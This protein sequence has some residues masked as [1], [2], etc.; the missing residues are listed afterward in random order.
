MELLLHEAKLGK[1]PRRAG[2]RWEGWNNVIKHQAGEA[3]AMRVLC[4]ALQVPPDQAQRQE[5]LAFVHDARKHLEARRYS[6]FTAQERSALRRKMEEILQE[7]DPDERLLTA[8]NETFF[9][10]V[11]ERTEGATW[12]EKID[13]TPRDELLQYYIDSLFVNGAIVP[14]LERIAETEQRRQD[15]NEDVERTRRLGMKYWDAERR[16]A[17]R[18]QEMIWGWL[19]ERGVGL[20]TPEHVPGYLRGEVE[21]E[22]LGGADDV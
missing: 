9:Y 13:R 16:M 11:F 8:T 12:E 10:R 3:V 20:P 4:R 15:L 22:I 21:K 2:E 14:P 19:R 6:D 18:V 1:K 7:I 5:T 17:T